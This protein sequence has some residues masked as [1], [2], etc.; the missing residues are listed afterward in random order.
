LPNYDAADFILHEI[1][2][3]QAFRAWWRG[4]GVGQPLAWYR[5]TQNNLGRD[6]VPDMVAGQDLPLRFDGTFAPEPFT[7]LRTPVG[8]Q[9]QAYAWPRV[10]KNKC[11]T[12]DATCSRTFQR[13]AT[14][15]NILRQACE[16]V[17]PN[18]QRAGAL[19][20]GAQRWSVMQCWALVY[21]W[22]RWP[23]WLNSLRH[24]LH[25][26]YLPP[27]PYAYISGRHCQYLGGAFMTAHV[28]VFTGVWPLAFTPAVTDGMVIPR[29]SIKMDAVEMSSEGVI[30]QACLTL[31]AAADMTAQYLR[32]SR[33]TLEGVGGKYFLSV[34]PIIRRQAARN[35]SL[36][37]RVPLYNS[38]VLPHLIL[39]VCGQALSYAN[40]VAS[41]SSEARLYATEAPYRY[42]I[43]PAANLEDEGNHGRM[44]IIPQLTTNTMIVASLIV[45]PLTCQLVPEALGWLDRLVNVE[46]A[47]VFDSAPVL[48][49]CTTTLVNDLLIGVAA[50]ADS[51]AIGYTWGERRMLQPFFTL[52]VDRTLLGTKFS[53]VLD[54]DRML[55]FAPSYAMASPPYYLQMCDL[56]CNAPPW[57]PDLPQGAPN[58]GSPDDRDP[59]NWD[60][61]LRCSVIPGSTGRLDF[62]LAFGPAVPTPRRLADGGEAT[63]PNA[64]AA[65]LATLMQ[66][67]FPPPV[68][69]GKQGGDLAPPR[70]V[71]PSL[72]PEQENV[73]LGQV[74]EQGV[75]QG[76]AAKVRLPADVFA[77]MLQ[78]IA[79]QGQGAV[80]Q[81]ISTYQVLADDPTPPP[82]A[83]A[84]EEV[85]EEA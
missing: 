47:L 40:K 69:D 42:L 74:R 12:D 57:Y 50:S 13:N 29:V 85:P 1:T 10:I 59:G 21:A 55:E 44:S 80:D 2:D 51:A 16:L 53:D 83:T 52:S 36:L 27:Q 4:A 3:Y 7:V 25:K 18:R 35:P 34:P 60:R 82:P 58:F 38:Q 8:E 66:R 6:E 56:R 61:A 72:A 30:A 31:R 5:L 11:Y 70:N 64:T 54:G 43:D 78:A 28:K 68:D 32:L 20:V 76:G 26:A 71:E 22:S 15:S 77:S 37:R 46:G 45:A 17:H 41:P 48:T 9:N 14:L 62:D 73:D 23:D 75:G 79:P 19:T 67:A 63:L 39:A 84:D 33:L 24:E 81:F 49:P 65:E